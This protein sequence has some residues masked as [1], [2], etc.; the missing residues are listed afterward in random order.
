MSPFLLFVTFSEAWEW[1]K[2]DSNALREKV[3]L[4]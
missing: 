2:R 3:F 4:R 1:G